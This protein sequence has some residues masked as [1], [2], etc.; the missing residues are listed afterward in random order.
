MSGLSDVPPHEV[1]SKE[2]A[3]IEIIFFIFKALQV[4]CLILVVLTVS[5]IVAI[6]Y[7]G[8]E[9]ESLIIEQVICSRVH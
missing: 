4:V 6:R 9:I 3:K 1:A 8:R 2:I 7:S 5:L